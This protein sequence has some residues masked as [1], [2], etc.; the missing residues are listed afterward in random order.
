MSP[1]RRAGSQSLRRASTARWMMCASTIS[2][3]RR[4]PL[5]PWPGRI[6]QAPCWHPRSWATGNSTKTDGSAAQNS[7][8]Y[9]NNAVLLNAPG[10]IAG[11][12]GKAVSFSP[13]N[14]YAQV[15]ST[16][17]LELGKNNADFTVAF[18]LSL[19][20]TSTG[21]VRSIVHK[22]ASDAQRRLRPLDAAGRQRAALPDQHERRRRGQRQRCDDRAQHLDPRCLRQGREPAAALPQRRTQFRRHPGRRDDRQQRSAL[23]RKN[24]M[25]RRIRGRPR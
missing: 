19:T 8:N 14:S 3:F 9:G 15:A 20:K 24:A 12:V 23:Y 17:G 4:K 13:V 1:G 6:P 18:W 7:S 16:P 10:W 21:A 25:E 2:R 5:S 11:R 22:G